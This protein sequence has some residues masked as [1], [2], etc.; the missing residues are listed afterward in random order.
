M[1]LQVV[2]SVNAGYVFELLL[3]GYQNPAHRC[4]DGSLCE[5]GEPNN[6]C[7][8]AFKICFTHRDTSLRDDSC[9]IRQF[10]TQT[11]ELDNDNLTFR[12]GE[13][14]GGV[15]NPIQVTGDTWPV[16]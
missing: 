13:T 6:L 9:H 3:L 1:S 7:D 10:S 8:N 14:I 5:R 16:S 4:F 11:I 15:D 12:E 2:L